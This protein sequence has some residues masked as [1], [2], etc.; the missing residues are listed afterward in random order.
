[1][2]FPEF[3]IGERVWYVNPTNLQ[4][5]T[6]IVTGRSRHINGTGWVYDIQYEGGVWS[7]TAIPEESLRQY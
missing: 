2:S 7:G 5:S 1:M 6:V 3:E 4:A